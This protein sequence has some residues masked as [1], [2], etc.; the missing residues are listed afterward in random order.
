MPYMS[1]SVQH[2]HEL[3]VAGESDH[4]HQFMAR[5][6]VRSAW[7]LTRWQHSVVRGFGILSP[8]L[9]FFF[10]AGSSVATR[11]GLRTGDADDINVRVGCSWSRHPDKIGSKG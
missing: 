7:G 5:P 1:F 4:S 6:L 11:Y 9:C 2:Y 8:T 3:L 10:A